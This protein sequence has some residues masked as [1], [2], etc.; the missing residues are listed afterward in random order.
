MHSN[1]H[2]E[3]FVRKIKH[4][5]LNHCTFLSEKALRDT[6]DIFYLAYIIT[7]SVRIRNSTA[8]TSSRT[9][10]IGKGKGDVTHISVIPGL[11]GYYYRA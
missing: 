4:E 3:Q 9:Q 10:L 7:P 1:Y 11:L 2:A 5:C 6:L 8:G